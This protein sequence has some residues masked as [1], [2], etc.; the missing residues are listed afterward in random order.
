MKTP[1][2][3]IHLKIE[4]QMKIDIEIHRLQ[5]EYLVYVRNKLNPTQQLDSIDLFYLMLL[6]A[7]YIGS[8]V[9]ILN[10]TGFHLF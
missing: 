4:I 5:N 1:F 6:N 7:Q 8:K 2:T 10:N 9:I 3:T